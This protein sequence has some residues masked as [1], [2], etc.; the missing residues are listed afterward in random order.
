LEGQIVNAGTPSIVVDVHPTL[1]AF[2]ES[3][4]EEGG[5]ELAFIVNVLELVPLASETVRVTV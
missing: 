4:G 3:E 1:A 2:K 5:K